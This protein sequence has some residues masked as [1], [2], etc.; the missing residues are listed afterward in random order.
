MKRL[1]SVF[2]LALVVAGCGQGVEEARTA[3]PVPTAG[4]PPAIDEVPVTAS[5]PVVVRPRYKGL[6]P[7][8]PDHVSLA[9]LAMG[10]TEVF[11]A[12]SADSTTTTMPSNT[13]LG[14]VSVYAVVGEPADGWVEVLLPVRPNGTTGWVRS[15]DVALYVVE[16][17]IVVDLS[18]RRLTF[19]E[20]GEEVLSTTVAVGTSANPTPTGQFYVTDSITMGYEGSPWG[21][22]AFGLSARS[23]T[24]TEFNG[25]DGII[26]IH[27][28]NKASS[29]GQAASLGCVRL[30]NDMITALYE[31]VPIGTPVEIRA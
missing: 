6:D 10:E 18:D 20:H 9:V 28:T 19:Y 11:D 21:P 27:G 31:M 8:L 16:G 13:I 29:I 25:G 23:D 2:V 12:P 14:T 22:H 4:I 26:G 3:E 30:P 24:I 7:D 1:A 5:D 17:R 15:E